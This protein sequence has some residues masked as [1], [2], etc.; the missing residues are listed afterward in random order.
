MRIIKRFC[1]FLSIM[2]GVQVI[3]YMNFAQLIFSVTLNTVTGV[4]YQNVFLVFTV[5]DLLAFFK[6]MRKDS[7]RLR[8]K[9]FCLEMISFIV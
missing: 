3:G 6:M 1:F 9:F 8:R 2:A 5:I 7:T 4:Y